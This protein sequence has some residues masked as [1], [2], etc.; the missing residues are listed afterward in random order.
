MMR[1]TGETGTDNLSRIQSVSSKHWEAMGGSHDG[2]CVRVCVWYACGEIGERGRVERDI[3]ERECVCVVVCACVVCVRDDERERER[4]RER[5]SGYIGKSV[6]VSE[7]KREKER[8]S[9]CV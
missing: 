2:A 1:K 3:G 7:R 6:C 9:V 5:E 4:E 8:E